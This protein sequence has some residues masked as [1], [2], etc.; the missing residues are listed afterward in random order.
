MASPF[1]YLVNNNFYQGTSEACIIDLTPPTFAGINFLDVE[2]RGQ[3][4]AGWSAAT[5]PLTPI[6]YQI[7]IQASTATGLFNTSNVIALTPNLQYDIFTLPNGAFL[8]NGTTYYVGVRAFDGVNNMD[9][10]TVSLSVISTGV[11]TSIDLYQ[12]DGVFSI[13]SSN[14]FQGTLWANKNGILAISPSATLGTAAYQVYDKAGN[15]VVGMNQS[16]ISANAEGQFIITAVSNLLSE[17]LDNYVV[18]VSISVDAEVR[19]N[20]V[21]IVRE[22]PDYNLNGLFFV[23]S[24]NNFDGSFWVSAN[25]LF[26]ATGLGNGSYQV[27]DQTGA[28]VVGMT[29]SGITPDVNGLYKITQIAS[30]LGADYLGFSVKITLTVDGITRSQ[31]LPFFGQ[32]YQYDVKGQFS[33]NA[34]N[35]LQ[36]TFW[37]AYSSNVVTASLGTANYQVYDVNGNV[38]IGLSETGITADANGRFQATAVSAALLTDLTHYSVKIGIVVDGIERVAYKGFTLLGT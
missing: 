14:Q 26:R 29:Q 24:G 23:D 4:R 28:P 34:L 32:V 6:R 18:K 20:Y 2:S 36:S 5:D 11:L 21:P 1:N 10:N 16:G 35:Q 31:M 7:Y 3:I 25:E 38:V 19:V 33:I 13:N 17:T 22:A 15:A 27:Y 37:V 30:L 9:S 8:Q 12:T